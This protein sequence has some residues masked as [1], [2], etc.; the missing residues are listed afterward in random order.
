MPSYYKGKPGSTREKQP[1][2]ATPSFSA[3]LCYLFLCPHPFGCCCSPPV[4]PVDLLLHTQFWQQLHPHSQGSVV[5]FA[6]GEH[7]DRGAAASRWKII[8]S[9][10]SAGC[11]H[12]CVAL[13]RTF[14]RNIY[15]QGKALPQSGE[16]G[17]VNLGL[18]SPFSIYAPL[19]LPTPNF[20]F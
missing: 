17:D 6:T 18:M 4:L 2:S 9:Q 14:H 16:G 8:H 1:K 19:H 15:H 11:S 3:S 12:C 10:P 7:R 20:T 5:A 13:H